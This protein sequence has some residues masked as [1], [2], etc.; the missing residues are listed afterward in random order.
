[1]LDALIA[2]LEANDAI[3]GSVASVVGLGSL[4]FVNGAQVFRRAFA[5]LWSMGKEKKQDDAPKAGRIG[6]DADDRRGRCPTVAVLPLNAMSDDAAHGYLAD[7]MTEDI[8]TLLSRNQALRVIA[9]NSTFAYKGQHFDIRKIGS[10]LGATYVVEGSVRRVGAKV[11]VT[12][13]L[14]EAA[15][16]SHVWAASFDRAVDEIAELQDEVTQGIVSS[17][18]P[19]LFKAETTRISRRRIENLEAWELVHQA[20]APMY[21]GFHHNRSTKESERLARR[22]LE[23]EP[24]NA[25]AHAVLAWALGNQSMDGL[26]ANDPQGRARLLE[27][28]TTHARKALAIERHDPLIL[29]CWGAV[30]SYDGRPQQ[31]ISVLRE[32]L[33]QDPNNVQAMAFLGNTL[34]RTG[35]AREGMTLIER[36]MS[37]S[38]ND[39]RRYLWSGYL[40][41]AHA[42]RGEFKQAY[43]WAHTSVHL[44]DRFFFGWF[45][46]AVSAAAIGKQDEADEAMRHVLALEPGFSMAGYAK[47]AMTFGEDPQMLAQLIDRIG[48]LSPITAAAQEPAEQVSG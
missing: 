32:A 36:A 10:E 16:G 18:Q 44:H 42:R 24:D 2:W 21:F 12:V 9:R 23:L 1:M 29:Y 7:G 40:S 5:N 37:L 14:I 8:I 39:P 4:F 17:L 3:L 38:P 43:A 11:R 6:P 45:L 28:A 48:T 35:E 30:L 47:Q 22:A 26:Y 46:V 20:L 33:V 41:W 25:R 34:A 31:S 15:G 27:E 19:E 13:Q